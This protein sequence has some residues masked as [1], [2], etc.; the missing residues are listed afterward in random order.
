M[1]VDLAMRDGHGIGA[2]FGHRGEDSVDVRP[3]P[4]GIIPLGAILGLIA[5]WMRK[6]KQNQDPMVAFG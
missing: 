2:C 1:S 3:M 5:P 6:T 4:T